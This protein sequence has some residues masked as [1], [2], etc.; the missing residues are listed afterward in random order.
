MSTS[1]AS[2]VGRSP[3]R[4]TGIMGNNFRLLPAPNGSSKDLEDRKIAQVLVAQAVFEQ[5]NFLRDV[6]VT[7]KALHHLRADLPVQALDLG[8]VRQVQHAE[9]EH[10]MGI[11]LAFMRVVKRLDFVRLAKILF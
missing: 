7:A 10:V 9:G 3:S 8:L 6:G 1:V 11:V 5:A 2:R 4:L